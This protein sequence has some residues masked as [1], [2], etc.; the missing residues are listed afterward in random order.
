MPE[1]NPYILEYTTDGV[2]ETVYLGM[3]P[4]WL[5]EHRERLDRADIISLIPKEGVS[6]PPLTV[7]L[8]KGQ[9][10]VYFK[11]TYK[12]T[13]GPSIALFC[14]GWQATVEGKN[15]K[16]LNWIYPDGYIE[17]VEEPVR[18]HELLKGEG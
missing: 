9:R 16:S 14:L 11:R 1:N 15:V 2:K 3:Q 4:Q 17:A 6:L 18:I 8:E 7:L 12:I 10:W 5:L 13:E